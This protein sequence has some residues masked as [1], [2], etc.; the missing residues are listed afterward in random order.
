MAVGMLRLASSPNSRAMADCLPRA[1][2][3][4]LP[5][6]AQHPAARAAFS[7]LLTRYNCATNQGNTNAADLI[8]PRPRASRDD[9][10][11]SMVTFKRGSSDH[12][13]VPATT[14]AT[15]RGDRSGC[16]PQRRSFRAG[17]SL[18]GLLRAAGSTLE[19]NKNIPGDGEARSPLS[20]SP[21]VGLAKLAL[22][23][24]DALGASRIVIAAAGVHHHRPAFL[25]GTMASEMPDWQSSNDCMRSLK[26][27]IRFGRRN[28]RFGH[29][30]S[31][32]RL[33]AKAR[34]APDPTWRPVRVEKTRL[35]ENPEAPASN[36]KWGSKC[37]R[38]HT[39]ATRLRIVTT[40]CR[41]SRCIRHGP[42]RTAFSFQPTC[43]LLSSA[44]NKSRRRGGNSN[45]DADRP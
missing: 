33:H 37:F 6:P 18:S 17:G 32:E 8:P 41:R 15:L 25:L 30:Y 7:Q 27:Q 28:S 22:Q 31:L 23:L 43:R 29:A 3:I 13:R 9:V 45:D 39:E 24:L 26:I 42:P 35:I 21:G 10:R 34:P 2:F 44:N 5:S 36:R 11:V 40:G 12:I 14:T 20:P 16:G 19:Q 1:A 4:Q 38:H